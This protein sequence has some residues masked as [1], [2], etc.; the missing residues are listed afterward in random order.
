[1]C[2]G[3][4]TSAVLS[5]RSLGGKLPRAERQWRRQ[6]RRVGGDAVAAKRWVVGKRKE[7]VAGCLLNHVS[8]KGIALTLSP[9]RAP[10]GPTNLLIDRRRVK[11]DPRCKPHTHTHT[12]SP[13]SQGPQGSRGPC[14]FLGSPAGRPSP[15]TTD[16][17]GCRLTRICRCADLQTTCILAVEYIMALRGGVGGGDRQTVSFS[18]S[19]CL[20][21]SG[22]AGFGLGCFTAQDGGVQHWKMESLSLLSF[23][24]RP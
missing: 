18:L 5:D 8:V 9:L 23:H 22:V 6:W 4:I 16:Y 2:A 14:L 15:T 1:M 13:L 17:S 3:I 7:R 24:T 11:R 19:G 20:W 12:C 21:N 10:S